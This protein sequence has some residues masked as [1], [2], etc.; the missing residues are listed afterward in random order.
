MILVNALV[1]EVDHLLPQFTKK[2]VVDLQSLAVWMDVNCE[3][4]SMKAKDA[5]LRSET[6]YHSKWRSME[7]FTSTSPAPCS[8]FVC[9]D[10]ICFCKNKVIQQSRNLSKKWH[11]PRSIGD[12]LSPAWSI[13]DRHPP[14]DSKKGIKKVGPFNF[15]WLLQVRSFLWL[16]R[17]VTRE[18]II[19]SVRAS[20]TRSSPLTF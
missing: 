7:A 12:L 3:R 17:P 18:C 5:F 2:R 14:M 8:F 20:P 10:L 4:M 9:L 11:L 6:F 16:A 19:G 15:D 1:R 13:E